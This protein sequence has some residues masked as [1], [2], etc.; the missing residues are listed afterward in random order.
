MGIIRIPV[1]CGTWAPWVGSPP[2]SRSR[3][4]PTNSTE[5]HGDSMGV[6]SIQAS[7]ARPPVTI[8]SW[9]PHP[10]PLPRRFEPD[11]GG[12]KEQRAGGAVRGGRPPPPWN[13]HR[14]P[15]SRDMI[16][17]GGF[18]GSRRSMWLHLR[19]HLMGGMIRIPHRR[20][21]STVDPLSD[22]G[23]SVGAVNGGE[24]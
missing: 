10:L 24:K 22:A 19:A 3:W 17:L 1:V 9:A 18:V 8:K 13:P 5:L 16:W 11:H 6:S 4:A 15:Q 23:R 21:D 20:V 2:S 7:E 14:H 12:S